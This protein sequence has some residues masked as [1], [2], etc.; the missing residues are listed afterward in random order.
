LWAIDYLLQNRLL[1]TSF[2]AAPS[3]RCPLKIKKQELMV[4]PTQQRFRTPCPA[5]PM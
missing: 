4:Q 1:G 3:R 2:E 5:K